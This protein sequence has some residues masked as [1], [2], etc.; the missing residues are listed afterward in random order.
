MIAT[1]GF[2]AGDVILLAVMVLLLVGSGFLALAETSLV[3][4]SKVKA[5]SLAEDKRK[6]SAPLTRLVEH[7]DRFL[8]P[9][10]LLVLVCQLVAATLV[11]VLA[12]RW[13]G[14]LGILVAT[15]FEVVVIFVVF[16]AIPKNFAVRHP[17]RAALFAAPIVDAITR[18]PPVRWLSGILVGIANLLM[19]GHDAG[20]SLAVTESELLAMADFA[21]SETR[22]PRNSG[23][24]VAGRC[25]ES[26]ARPQ[27]E[28]PHRTG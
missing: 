23:R 10:L 14:P 27:F 21:R 5:Y 16:E 13:F 6:G 19:G 28:Y 2:R 18:F 17:E 26:G 8:N 24:A 7:P 11:G 15:V 4:T 9:V 20:Q 3:R 1:V 22:R 25:P 12:S